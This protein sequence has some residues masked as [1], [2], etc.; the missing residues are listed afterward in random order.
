MTPA[1]STTPATPDNKK[2]LKVAVI[3]VLSAGA[4]IGAYF[5]Y[6]YYIKKDEDGKT[7]ADLKKE[8]KEGGSGSGGGGGKGGGN[9]GL[10]INPSTISSSDFPLEINSR[11]KA[12]ILMQV[13]LKHKWSQPMTVDGRF[14]DETRL[15]LINK[16]YSFFGG[17]SSPTMAKA[18]L[19]LPFTK[20]E[21]NATQFASIVKGVDFN[22]IFASNPDYKKVFTQYQNFNSK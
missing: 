14:G 4:L 7:K 12:V 19:S 20:M 9:T 3:S 21:I 11:N 10:N 16:F 13:A 6:D 5:G 8:E 2:I 1:T 22:S 17:S 15:A 18:Y